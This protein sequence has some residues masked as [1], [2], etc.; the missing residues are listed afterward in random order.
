MARSVLCSDICIKPRRRTKCRLEGVV[1]LAA[2]HHPLVLPLFKPFKRRQSHN[3]RCAPS[4]ETFIPGGVLCRGKREKP[5][6]AE[7]IG[8]GD[9][10]S[11]HFDT[12]VAWFEEAGA[13]W[14]AGHT[15]EAQGAL[16]QMLPPPGSASCTSQ[17]C[18]RGQSCGIPARARTETVKPGVVSN[19]RS[20]LCRNMEAEA[21]S[22]APK[23]SSSGACLL[24]WCPST[25]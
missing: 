19:C 24:R 7:R 13:L 11:W 22:D 1:V 18:R 16:H 21:E 20:Y 6:S 12:E 17:S 15:S 5:A 14:N 3:F 8:N 4:R 2:L 25:R 23:S 9:V 10:L